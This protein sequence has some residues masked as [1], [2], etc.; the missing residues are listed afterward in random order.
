MARHGTARHPQRKQSPAALSI[1]ARFEYT[2]A[3]R[4]SVM[5]STA[6]KRKYIHSKGRLA[7][8]APFAEQKFGQIIQESM[9]GTVREA[10][11]ADVCFHLSHAAIS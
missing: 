2:N 11:G 9:S 5:L 8:L 4:E 7:R 1:T 6:N 10:N 3:N